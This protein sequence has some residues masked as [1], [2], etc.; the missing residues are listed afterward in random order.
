MYWSTWRNIPDDLKSVRHSNLQK[1]S[2]VAAL[3]INLISVKCT[4]VEI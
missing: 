3:L 1:K 2:F 4:A